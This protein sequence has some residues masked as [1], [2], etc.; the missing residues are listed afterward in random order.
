MPGCV[1]NAKRR[2]RRPKL[3]DASK[4]NLIIPFLTLAAIVIADQLSKAYA[5]GSLIEGQARQVM[6]SFFQLKLVYNKGGA[7]GTSFGGSTFYLV[8]SLLILLIVI[9]FIVVNR[10]KLYF[11]LPM[12]AIA[13][14]A[15][16]NIID[17]IR[18]GRVIDFLDFD[19]FNINMMGLHID[20]W[21]IF[22]IAD[23]A[24]TVGVIALLVFLLISGRSVHPASN[25][26]ENT[27][28]NIA[29]DSQL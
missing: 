24:I 11:T 21:W 6:G 2:K 3:A 13:G 16:G 19:F 4:R 7:L 5:L 9:Y 25:N 1:L 18:L 8:S 15:V 23:A 27:P 20:R 28:E 29:P 26:T 12:G 10:D 22:N 17:R 14:G